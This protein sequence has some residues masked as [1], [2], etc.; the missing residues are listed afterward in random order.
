MIDAIRHP[1][2]I[3]MLGRLDGFMGVIDYKEYL[4]Q[5]PV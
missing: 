3:E 1:I 2:I 5:C 4:F